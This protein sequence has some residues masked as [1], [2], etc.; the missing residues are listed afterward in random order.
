MR[1]LLPFFDDSTL[2][3]AA[4]MRALLLDRSV[5][6]V[7]LMESTAKQTISERQLKQHLPAGP[8]ISAKD[9]FYASAS[10]DEFD[11][12]IFCKVPKVVRRL[13]SDGRIQRRPDRPAFVAFQ[14]G[15]EFTPDRGRKNRENFDIVFLNNVDHRDRFKRGVK[16]NHWQ[17]VSFGHPY[18]LQGDAVR[19]TGR[20]IY[21]FA[22]AI[23]P[24]SLESRRFIMDMLVTLA[25]RHPD[26]NVYVKLR[27]LPG[28]NA[29]HVHREK[30][31]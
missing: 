3:F 19:P 13:L 12:A 29:T 7:T 30:Y 25:W 28:E 14:P 1:V 8:D 18:F 9:G 20:D 27:H 6:A 26:R 15:L 23:S 4:K 17:Y 21:F 5:E 10:M 11:A 24:I 22:Q 31:D 16:R 2:I